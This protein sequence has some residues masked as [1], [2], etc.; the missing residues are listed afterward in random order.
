MAILSFRTSNYAANIYV[1]G[2]TRFANIP[3]E[4]HEPVK[5]YAAEKYTVMPYAPTENLTRQLDIALTNAWITV[6]EHEET[7]A[8]TNVIE[9]Q[10]E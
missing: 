1:H 5:Q 10:N 3:S 6:Q 8:Y 4:Y 9:E 2:N 7:V